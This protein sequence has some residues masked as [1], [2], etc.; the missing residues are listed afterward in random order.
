MDVANRYPGSDTMFWFC[1]FGAGSLAV[2]A[3]VELVHVGSK[4]GDQDEG[5][6]SASLDEKR[7]ATSRR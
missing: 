2:R 3:F 4:R 5:V 6:D 7:R 1:V